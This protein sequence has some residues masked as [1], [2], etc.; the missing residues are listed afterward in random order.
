MHRAIAS[1][2]ALVLFAAGCADEALIGERVPN[3]APDTQVEATP[4]NLGA[5]TFRITLFWSGSD[6][7][8]TVD[9]YEWII[10]DNGSDGILS[11]SDTTGTW[12]YTES[13]DSTFVVSAD[14]PDFG[15]DV[16][17]PGIDDVEDVRYWQTHTFLV[18]AVDD[19]G[20]RDPSPAHVSFTATTLAPK[21]EI[22]R[23]TVPATPSCVEGPL[24]LSFG[25]TAE[26]PDDT[27]GGVAEVRYLLIEIGGPDDR[28]LTDTQ[29]RDSN[30]VASAPE[31]AWSEWI[32]YEA[33]Q[34]SGRV[35][36]YR[37]LE[38]PVG[39]S[40]IFAVQA[41]DVAGAVTPTFDWGVNVRHVK[42]TR[43][44]FPLLTVTESNLGTTVGA[45]TSTLLRFDIVAG[46]PLDFSWRAEA[47]SYGGVIEAFRYGFGVV[48]PN[49]E[50]DPNWS[51]PWGPSWRTARRPT[52]FSQGSP[53]FV[54]QVR[55]NSGSVSRI[56][57]QFQV[58]QIKARKDQR[59]LLVVD[60]D[61]GGGEIPTPIRRIDQQWDEEWRRT[62]LRVQGFASAS[63]MIDTATDANRLTFSLLNDYRA[64]I[65]LVR[66]GQS[67]FMTTR[68]A[69]PNPRGARFNW[70]QV[71]QKFVGNVMLAGPAA[72]MQSV[73]TNT[74]DF[75]DFPMPL[76][77]N[78]SDGGNNGLGT[79]VD[80]EGRTVNVGTLR[81]AY[82][83]WCLD[84]IDWVRPFRVYGERDGAPRR[85]RI[86]CE[87]YTYARV[88]PDFVSEFRPTVQ[89]VTHLR[90]TEIRLRAGDT[91]VDPQ[92]LDRQNLAA[93]GAEEFYNVNAAN[94]P[95]LVSPRE[96][97]TP[98]FLAVARM[99]VDNAEVMEPE[100]LPERYRVGVQER[101]VNL[102]ESPPGS[103]Q[104]VDDCPAV[105]LARRSTSTITHAPVA[106]ASTQYLRERTK[107]GGTLLTEDYIWGFN[108]LT[109]ERAEFDAVMDWI[110]LTRWGLNDE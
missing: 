34:D 26:D 38:Q 35:K 67:S 10:T 18:R 47:E 60:D 98:M 81:Y 45:G 87:S 93:L 59:P 107:Q 82:T 1:T 46:Q 42:T 102:T 80:A 25:W 49:D 105:T 32:P 44:K 41:R 109:F 4:P 63:D 74:S 8:G 75:T 24:A 15:P 66:T 110:L 53:N 104:L 36:R 52:G 22:D 84:T 100:D 28:C 30:P 13:T 20:R 48:D 103:G 96:C 79:I 86:G 90:P 58:I 62:L 92:L 14:I 68:F 69:P 78:T 2:L 23:P 50:E 106:I 27:R 97:Q 9:G 21:I 51:V 85:R 108:P 77:L 71:Y 12:N 3:S 40:Y 54:L 83:S 57:Y 101:L 94:R 16:E 76:V 91:T 70:L 11:P 95:V 19:R 7:D 72:A 73:Q 5:S 39:T 55:D 65:W 61:T 89:E 17:N 56:S 43:N 31:T 6:L 29:F 37:I 99:D 64:V 88:S 33:G